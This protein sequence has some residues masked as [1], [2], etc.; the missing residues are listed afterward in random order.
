MEDNPA[1]KDDM[2]HTGQTV[3]RGINY[4]LHGMAYNE[5]IKTRSGCETT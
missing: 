4:M 3:A 2:E 1:G 5:L